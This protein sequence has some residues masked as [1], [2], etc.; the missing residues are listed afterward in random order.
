MKADKL[1]IATTNCLRYRLDCGKFSSGL[2]SVSIEEPLQ[3]S[4]VHD[5]QSRPL[6]L[7]M[8]TPGNDIELIT[9]FL[10][11]E[12]VISNPSDLI[13]VN[14]VD[15][16]FGE[17]HI[18]VE[19]N[20]QLSIDWQ[21]IERSFA[22]FASCGLCGKNSIKALA[23]KHQVDI[24]QQEKWLHCRDISH[25]ISELTEHQQQFK[26]TGGVHSAAY[27][28]D[29]QWLSIREDIGRHNAL[30]KVLGHCLRESLWQS[31]SLLLL[32]GRISYELMQKAVAAQVPVV[33]AIGA[34][35]S[36]AIQVAQQFNITLVGFTKASRFNVYHGDW[37]IIQ[38]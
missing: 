26:E 15:D 4:L 11:A 12:G 22:S 19:I 37:R 18:E 21:K 24:N 1:S 9:G 5:D 25:L 20:K 10:F 23:L 28:A 8:R 32:S 2:E 38:E 6:T 7:M 31:K 14:T 30:D 36:L 3:V 27:I 17:N 34:P 33:I 16:E 35:S 29:G 13:S